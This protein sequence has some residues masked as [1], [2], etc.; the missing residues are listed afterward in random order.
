MDF[1]W[2]FCYS[3]STSFCK[4]CAYSMKKG[5]LLL[6]VL[7]LISLTLIA[8]QALPKGTEDSAFQELYDRSLLAKEYGETC[9]EKQMESFPSCQ[10]VSSRYGF[11]TSDPPVYLV[12][13]SYTVGDRSGVY[14]YK[15]SVDDDLS[16]QILEEGTDVAD[17]LF[18]E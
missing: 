18:S 17:F 2:I 16:C 15:I 3:K 11:Y 1:S 6:A 9:F 7:C 12:G 13:F 5:F 10:I 4:E 8:C 14:A